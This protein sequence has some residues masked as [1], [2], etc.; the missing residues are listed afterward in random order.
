[1]GVLGARAAG[2]VG[3][4]GRGVVF[5]R[6]A[7]RP[8]LEPLMGGPQCR[9]SILRNGN[10]ACRYLKKNPVDP[11]IPQCHL[12]VLRSGNV[13]CRYFCTVSVDLK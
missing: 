8:S 3:F 10:V 9:L 12:S 6:L 11:K 2:R 1:M 4:P 13:P 5:L 7:D